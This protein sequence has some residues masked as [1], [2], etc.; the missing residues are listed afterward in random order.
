MN[1]KEY[2]SEEEYQKNKKKI[3]K[4]ALI[5]LIVGVLIGGSLIATGIIKSINFVG[6]DS[7]GRTAE[8]IQ[9][10]IDALNDELALLKAQKSEEFGNNGLSE[11]YY[12]LQNEI[13]NK[14]SEISDLES[15]LWKIESGYNATKDRISKAK[16]I[17]FYMFGA[18]IILASCMFAGSIYM[19]AKRREITAFTAQQVMPVAQEGIEKMAPSIGKVAKEVSKGIKEGINSDEE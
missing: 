16:Y 19:F 9:V 12:R 6:S 15:E 13:S 3:T 14:N 7:N 17:P 11:D 5:I 2:L 1:K 10:E 4:I 8:V 18:F